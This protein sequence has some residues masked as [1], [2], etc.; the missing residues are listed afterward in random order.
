MKENWVCLSIV[1]SN[2]G[3]MRVTEDRKFKKGQITEI[4]AIE[5]CKFI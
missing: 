4:S 1:Y 3:H 5:D 2:K